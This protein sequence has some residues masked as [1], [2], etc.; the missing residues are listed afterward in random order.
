MIKSLM[1][2][3]CNTFLFASILFSIAKTTF[4]S[5]CYKSTLISWF[6]WCT[7][8]KHENIGNYCLYYQESYF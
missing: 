6:A 8:I 7:R 1:F 4:A 2:V 5:N 3:A